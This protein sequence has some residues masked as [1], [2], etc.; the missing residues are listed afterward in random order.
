MKR[1]AFALVLSSLNFAPCLADDKE[2][3]KEFVQLQGTWKAVQM[4]VVGKP[5]SKEQF[6][7]DGMIFEF[8]GKE[9]TPSRGGKKSPMNVKVTLNLNAVPSQM[10]LDMPEEGKTLAIYKI[11]KDTLTVCMMPDGKTRPAKFESTKESG[12]VLFVFEREKK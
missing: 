3:P 4:V 6:V 12:T 9:M 2:L 8:K 11:E 5:A 1:L 7:T 10:D